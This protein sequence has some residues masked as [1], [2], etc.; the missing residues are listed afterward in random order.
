[1]FDES[2]PQILR[3]C[4]SESMRMSLGGKVLQCKVCSHKHAGDLMAGFSTIDVSN[5]V[6][7]SIKKKCDDLYHHKPNLDTHVSEDSITFP[8]LKE[9]CDIMTYHYPL[10]DLSSESPF[11]YNSDVQNHIASRRMNEQNWK[12]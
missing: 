10:D 11:Y 3:D 8:R 5:M 4:M 7:K 9:R 12:H 2:E 6:L 1:M